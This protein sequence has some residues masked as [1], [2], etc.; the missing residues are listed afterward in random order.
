MLWPHL[1][2]CNWHD[3]WHHNNTCYIVTETSPLHIQ[4]DLED[5]WCNQ[6]FIRPHLSKSNPTIP[7]PPR[8]AKYEEEEVA[9]RQK[10]P[11]YAEKDSRWRG[12]SGK[13]EFGEEES[14]KK[15]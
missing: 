10:A 12:E 5:W 8:F 14:E 3:T 4:K 6:I 9:L 15:E 7:F 1:L 11:P 13:D 2:H